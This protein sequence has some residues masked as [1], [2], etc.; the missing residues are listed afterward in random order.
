MIVETRPLIITDYLR[1]ASSNST[2]AG[3][4][5]WASGTIGFCED[6]RK[7]FHKPTIR[8]RL[9]VTTHSV[10]IKN[11]KAATITRD[12]CNVTCRVVKY[13][14]MPGQTSTT[15]TTTDSK[16]IVSSDGFEKTWR[17]SWPLKLFHLRRLLVKPK[18]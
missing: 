16:L 5:S 2:A 11:P 10:A 8:R 3:T 9:A 12:Q 4:A 7:S 17:R 13:S 15:D 1:L 14:T 18:S 6:A